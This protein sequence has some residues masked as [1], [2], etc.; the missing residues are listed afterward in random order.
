[1]NTLSQSWKLETLQRELNFYANMD[2]MYWNS[3]GFNLGDNRSILMITEQTRLME[4]VWHDWKLQ[5]KK[6]KL[7]LF[8]N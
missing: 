3:Y 7:W 5:K 2:R 4:A 1:M 8:S 6:S